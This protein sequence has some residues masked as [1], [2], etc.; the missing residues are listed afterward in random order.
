MA[1]S[2]GATVARWL[3]RPGA[4]DEVVHELDAQGE[5]RAGPG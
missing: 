1:G 2:R 3:E 5:R 4:L